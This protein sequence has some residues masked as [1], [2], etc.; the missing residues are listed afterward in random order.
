MPRYLGFKKLPLD[1]NAY[2]LNLGS[3][4]GVWVPVAKLPL[5]RE[6]Q[7]LIC[8]LSSQDEKAGTR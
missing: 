7:G 8:A 4:D 2:Q 3:T 5:D 1:L 6:S